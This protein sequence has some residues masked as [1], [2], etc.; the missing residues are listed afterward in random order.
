M[1][2]LKDYNKNVHYHP[3]KA[4]VVADALSRMRM[5]STTHVEDKKKELLKDIHRLARLGMRLV[6]STSWGI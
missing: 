3:D 2:L 4:N 1:E 5:G 6:D